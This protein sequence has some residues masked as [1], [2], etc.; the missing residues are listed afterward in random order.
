MRNV[1][2]VFIMMLSVH[3]CLIGQNVP[4]TEA[5]LRFLGV[6]DPQDLDPD[7]VDRLEH[8]MED[9]VRINMMDS[10]ALRSTG[11][12][13]AYQIAVV[14]DYISRHGQ[15]HSLTELSLLDGFGEDFTTRVAPFI[16]LDTYPKP[17]ALLQFQTFFQTISILLTFCEKSFFPASSH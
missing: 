15:I 6:E 11:L 10:Q 1:L 7:E 12:F 3:V 5:V 16:T 8:M 2:S 9:P 13:S 4:Q 17:N 14:E